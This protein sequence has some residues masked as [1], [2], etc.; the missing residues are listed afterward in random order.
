MRRSREN[1][2]MASGL[3]INT[4]AFLPDGRRSS[5]ASKRA[6]S[7]EVGPAF[8]ESAIL[9]IVLLV[10]WEFLLLTCRTCR[11]EVRGMCWMGIK[12]GWKSTNQDRNVWM[13]VVFFGKEKG[14]RPEVFK[15]QVSCRRLS[16]GKLRSRHS[17]IPFL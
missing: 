9:T 11:T 15:C 7:P 6:I 2:S 10:V 1:N 17:V 8:I 14:G 16:P 12:L 13:D 4:F 5:F 3:G